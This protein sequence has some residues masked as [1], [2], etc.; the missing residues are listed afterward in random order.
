MITLF[1]KKKHEDPLMRKERFVGADNCVVFLIEETKIDTPDMQPKIEYSVKEY[2]PAG[3]VGSSF[4][5]TL[6]S[7]SRNIKKTVEGYQ[8]RYADPT[9]KARLI[10]TSTKITTITT[11]SIKPESLVNGLEDILA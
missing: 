8:K 5:Y 9:I 10:D 7:V 1:R 11:R 6:E 4:H 3:A 2:L